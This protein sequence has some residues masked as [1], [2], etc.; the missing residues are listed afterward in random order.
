MLRQVRNNTLTQE[1]FEFLQI[2]YNDKKA[3]NESLVAQLEAVGNLI[4]KEHYL[5][6]H[7]ETIKNIEEIFAFTNIGI[8]HSIKFIINI[9]SYIDQKRLLEMYLN[10]ENYANKPLFIVNNWLSV[11]DLEDGGTIVGWKSQQSLNPDNLMCGLTV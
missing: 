7:K 6:N 11:E 1:I 2:A 10:Y 8:L 4:K 5:T 3:S 9:L